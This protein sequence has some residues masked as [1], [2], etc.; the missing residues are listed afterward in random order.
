MEDL[1]IVAKVRCKNCDT[2]S[3]VKMKDV[4]LVIIPCKGCSRFMMFGSSE[5]ANL[6]EEEL[7]EVIDG[8]EL[9]GCGS[10]EQV[11]LKDRYQKREAKF[12][13]IEKEIDELIKGDIDGGDIQEG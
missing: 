1:I 13:E 2:V 11:I 4:P 6:S 3:M 5:S 12:D 10:V 8:Q 7:A 9:E